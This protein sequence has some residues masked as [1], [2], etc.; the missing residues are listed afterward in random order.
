MKGTLKYSEYYCP[1]GGRI[2]R[3]KHQVLEPFLFFRVRYIL[4]YY[5]ECT[6]CKETSELYEADITEQVKRDGYT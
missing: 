2:V 3:R 1:C 6:H 4:E 5:Y